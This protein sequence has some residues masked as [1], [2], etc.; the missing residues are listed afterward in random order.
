MPRPVYHLKWTETAVK[1]AERSTTNGG[2]RDIYE[3]ARKLL[4][5]GLLRR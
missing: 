4:K 5:Q 3:L 1:L 2:T